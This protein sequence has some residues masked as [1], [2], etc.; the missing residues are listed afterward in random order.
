[1]KNRKNNKINKEDGQTM[2]EFVLVLPVFMLILFLILDC[3]W[4]FYNMNTV[5]NSARNAARVAC[6]EYTDTCYNLDAFTGT[7]MLVES[8]NY[9]LTTLGDI[10][11][12]STLTQEEKDILQQV[13]ISKGV[14]SLFDND[15]TEHHT[16]VTISYSGGND[17]DGTTVEGRR[18]G[19]VTVQVKC[20]L[21]TFTTI[22]NGKDGFYKQLNSVSTFKVEKNAETVSNT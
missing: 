21:K 20:Y 9:D 19:D 22:L 6:V 3:G 1:M 8:K 2:L 16:I 4:L 12:N 10:E 13:T 11:T 14:T 18:E 7:K 5:E 15:D 17:F